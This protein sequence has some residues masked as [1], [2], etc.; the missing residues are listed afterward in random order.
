[1]TVYRCTNCCTPTR[2]EICDLIGQQGVSFWVA[3]VMCG[4]GFLCGWGCRC[5][6][7]DT[8][9][10]S[11]HDSLRKSSQLLREERRSCQSSKRRRSHHLLNTSPHRVQFILWKIYKY[12]KGIHTVK[13][14]YTSVENSR[15]K[16]YYYPTYRVESCHKYKLT[17]AVILAAAAA[18]A[19]A[20]AAGRPPGAVGVR[21]GT[22]GVTAFPTR[23]Y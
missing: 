23:R 22:G 11:S 9:S 18:A 2:Q 6:C 10:L 16:Y 19:T 8:W 15:T 20:A 13:N 3:E 7:D 14:I 5:T 12:C 17:W 1:M 4:V 21:R